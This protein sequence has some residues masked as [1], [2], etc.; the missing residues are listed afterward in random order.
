[1]GMDHVPDADHCGRIDVR[2]TSFSENCLARVRSL[3]YGMGI[4]EENNQKEREDAD[5]REACG[6]Q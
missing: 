6:E 3:K 1:M 4:R 2:F 5:Y